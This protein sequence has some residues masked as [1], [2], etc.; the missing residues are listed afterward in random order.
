MFLKV[1]LCTTLTFLHFL[2]KAGEGRQWKRIVSWQMHRSFRL[3]RYRVLLAQ[4]TWRNDQQTCEYEYAGMVWILSTEHTSLC[5]WLSWPHTPLPSW[6]HEQRG[7]SSISTG[8]DHRVIFSIT[9]KST[10]LFLYSNCM[11]HFLPWTN[12]IVV[13]PYSLQNRYFKEC[14]EYLHHFL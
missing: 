3:A 1:C 11:E 7:F 4:Q 13:F 2:G 8:C 10:L 5:L 12:N 9:W 14:G 6:K